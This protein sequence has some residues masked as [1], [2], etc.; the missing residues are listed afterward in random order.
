MIR[1]TTAAAI[2][3]EVAIAGWVVVTATNNLP[4][5][6]F[7]WARKYD[8][9]VMFLPN[10]RFFAPNPAVHDYRLAHRILW[11]DDSSSEW[12]DTK[13]IPYRAWY[14]SVWFPSR[15]RD[16][17]I[18]DMSNSLIE[19]MDDPVKAVERSIAY[20]ALSNLV[21]GVVRS[22]LEAGGPQPQG[23]QFAV[24]RDSGYDDSEAPTVFFTSR[25]ERWD[26]QS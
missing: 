8:P 2:A 22:G 21:R 5:R 24:G 4:G 17:A 19:R 16:K 6:A 14:N 20:Q 25:F 13:D 1:P 7:D 12:L 23:Y 9:A 18:T 15:R 3:A 26:E 11:D 10:W